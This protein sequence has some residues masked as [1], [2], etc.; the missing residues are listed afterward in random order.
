MPIAQSRVEQVQIR[1]LIYSVRTSDF[2]TVKRICEKGTNGII[3]YN[4]PDDG[5]TPLMTAVLRNDE[6]MI[7]FLLDL[8][9][10]CN[11]RTPLMRAAGHGFVESVLTLINAKADTTIRDVNGY[12]VLFSCL[13]DGSTRQ[14]ECFF[15]IS[16]I[17]TNFD[18]KSS[19]G[20]PLLVAACEKAITNERLCLELINRAADVNIIDEV[21]HTD[22][23]ICYIE[24]N[25][26]ACFFQT[27]GLS[28][29][30]AACESGM[31]SIV[32]ELLKRGAKVNGRDRQ[33]QTPVHAAVKSRNFNLLPIL[34]AYNAS[35]NVE[36]INGNTPVH[37]AAKFNMGQMIKYMVQRGAETKVRNRDNVL[38]I[39]IAKSQKNKDAIKS[40]QLLEKKNY[41]KL[42][43]SPRSNPDRDYKIYLY[44]FIYENQDRLQRRF[45]HVRVQSADRVPSREMK[46]ILAEEGFTQ[47]H[48]DDLNDLIIL[49]ETNPNEFDYKTFLSGKLFVEKAYMMQQFLPKNKKKKKKKVAKK[50]TSIPIALRDEGPRTLNGNP[51]LVYIPKH[52]FITDVNRFSRDHIPKHIANDDSAWYL[53]KT[54]PNFVHINN[55]AKRG[56]LHTMLDAFKMGVP[57]DIQD[58]YYTTP[59]MVAS[60]NGDVETVKFLIE[61]G[62]NVNLSDNFKWTPL[63]HAAHAGHLDCVKLLVE[64]GARVNTESITKAT[65]LS[66]AIESSAYEVVEY[67]L[68]KRAVVQHEN[69]MGRKKFHLINFHE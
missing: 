16:K 22:V 50:Q 7:Q 24:T 23:Y 65:P 33:G 68:E 57:V 9:A 30:M 13:S 35:F 40:I 29:L 58:K 56:D 32:R 55:A 37:L 43:S 53:D 67:L 36:D 59:L 41:H 61:C 20:K 6:V 4:N 17:I 10:N 31:I 28:P 39:K 15:L 48:Q 51:P 14:Q 42:L 25:G 62:A 27:T 8:G 49:H 66:R 26:R 3:N 5:D 21:L 1:K 46:T 18:T 11:R 69:I 38:P 12:D 19:K 54:E 44:D 45:D 60:A 64:N 34:S 47:I 2:I 52:Q 63:H